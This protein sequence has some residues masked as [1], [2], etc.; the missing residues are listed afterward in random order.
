VISSVKSAKPPSEIHT[1]NTAFYLKCRKYSS[2]TWSVS[3][4]LFRKQIN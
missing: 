1:K 2:F 4:I 3:I